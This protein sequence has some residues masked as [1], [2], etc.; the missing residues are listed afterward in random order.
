MLLLFVQP[1]EGGVCYRRGDIVHAYIPWPSPGPPRCLLFPEPSPPAPCSPCAAPAPR[2]AAST[3]AVPCRAGLRRSPAWQRCA[4]R[5]RTLPV[6]HSSPRLSWR[7][8]HPGRDD[9]QVEGLPGREWDGGS[10]TPT[11]RLPEILCGRRAALRTGC[12]GA[13]NPRGRPCGSARSRPGRGGPAGCSGLFTASSPPPLQNLTLRT[14]NKAVRHRGARSATWS[15]EIKQLI[16]RFCYRRGE[17]R[18]AFFFFSS[19]RYAT[20]PRRVQMTM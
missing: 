20:A 19:L 10:R 13:Q 14:E 6:D 2:R 18:S 12:Q 8:P 7:Y 16:T 15:G 9:A 17:T 5:T 4:R 3:R 1:R 11:R